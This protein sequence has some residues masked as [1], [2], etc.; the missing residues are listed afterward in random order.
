MV[1]NFFAV[2]G[3]VFYI[4]REEV[5]HEVGGWINVIEILMG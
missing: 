3:D 2:R 4:P 5:F 1:S